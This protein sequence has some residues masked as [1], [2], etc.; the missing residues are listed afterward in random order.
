MHKP[1][2]FARIDGI[3]PQA[4]FVTIVIKERGVLSLPILADREDQTK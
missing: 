4:T 1:Q 3:D 2:Q